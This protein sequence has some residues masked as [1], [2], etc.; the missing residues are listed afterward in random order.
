MIEK[1]SETVQVYKGV[2]YSLCGKYF[3]N[4]HLKGEKRLH[5]VVYIDNFG[6]IPDGYDVHHKDHDRSNNAISN[7][8]VISR[9]EH[10]LHHWEEKSDEEKAK[11]LDAQPKAVEEAKEWH[12]S[13][14]GTNWHKEHY[15]R[16]KDKLFVKVDVKCDQCGKIYQA[17][18]GAQGKNR[19]CSN[20]CTAKHRRLSG[21]DDIDRKCKNCGKEFRINKYARREFCCKKCSY[22][23]AKK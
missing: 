5:R 6:D 12:N 2:R 1:A 4:S 19:F 11:F 22:D 14:D 21:I 15:E 18:S 9:R 10:H 13:E 20:K 23:Y 7:L 8:C 16:M 17:K 3:Q